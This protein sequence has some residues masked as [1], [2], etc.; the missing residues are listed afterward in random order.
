[1]TFYVFYRKLRNFTFSRAWRK[2]VNIIRANGIWSTDTILF[3]IRPAGL[4]EP[5]ARPF[6]GE[7]R[8][9]TEAELPACAADLKTA[10]GW[11]AAQR[12]ILR[13]GELVLFGWLDGTCVFHSYLQYGGI[14]DHRG[15]AVR[16]A[17]NE[18]YIHNVFCVPAARRKGFHEAALRHM[19][20]ACPDR[21]L[22]TQAV[23]DNVPS[24]R[25]FYRAGFRPVFR[26]TV[27]KRFFHH[28]VSKVMI[29]EEEAEALIALARSQ[30]GYQYKKE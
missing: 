20:A 30:N 10:F 22:Y 25:G 15:H 24:L 26:H 7:I 12:S 13:Q 28:T 9:P 27:K 6:A 19:C 16:F 18:A 23:E 17:D 5:E 21:V 11:D 3:L 4:P 1:M 2:L 14:Y 8:V 29:G